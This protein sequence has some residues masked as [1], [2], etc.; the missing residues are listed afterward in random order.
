MNIIIIGDGEVGKTSILK[1]FDKR[2]APTAHIR[3]TG[4]DYIMHKTEREGNALEVKL[5][6]TAGQEQ[7]KTLTYSFYAKADA[8]IV[9]FDLTSEKS[10]GNCR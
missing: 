9:T 6:D 5:W 3:T 8:I 4:I 2:V 1:Y 10:F 7:F